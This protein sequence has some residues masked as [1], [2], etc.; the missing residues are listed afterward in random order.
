MVAIF[1]GTRA[2]AKNTKDGQNQFFFGGGE[3]EESNTA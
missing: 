3:E 1:P 2:L